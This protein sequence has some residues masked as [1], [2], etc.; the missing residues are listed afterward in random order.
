[1]K[2]YALITGASK[3]LGLEFAKLFAKDGYPLVIV[4]RSEALL[5][6]LKEELINN[7]HVKVV[8]ITKDL[9]NPSSA[10]Q[11][12]N[13]I[14][15]KKIRIDYLINNAGFGDYGYFLDSSV[16]YQINMINLNITTLMQLCYYFGNDM[17]QN[18]FGKIMN[19]GSIASFFSGPFMATYYATKAFVLSFSEAL[20]KE[21]KED[22]I[23]VTTL[24]PGT[25][26]TNFF[27]N[28]S[29]T[30]DKTNLLKHMHPAKPESVALYG[31]KKMMKNKVVAI[32]G[33]KNRLAV[34]MNRFISRKFSR[35]IVYKIQ[36]KRSTDSK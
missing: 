27:N 5:A 15:N 17:R 6:K 26:A 36:K 23:T 13:E 14:K 19:I 2:N 20:S 28:A 9:S 31:Y 21:L 32:A 29:A 1:M 33:A 10:S 30:S 12:Y 35:N 24:C 11:L 8:V 18:K 3:G 4:A 34:F 25:T 16:D 22:G 7:Y